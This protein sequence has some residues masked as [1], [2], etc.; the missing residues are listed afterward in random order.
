MVAGLSAA[1]LADVGE[2]AGDE[3]AGDGRP[4]ETAVT[5]S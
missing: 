2:A 4:T 3:Q 5:G 1:L